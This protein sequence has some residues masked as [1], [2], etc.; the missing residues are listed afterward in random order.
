MASSRR[1]SITDLS[2]EAHQLLEVVRKGEP[3]LVESEGTDEAI[4][5][6][7]TDY[8]LLRAAMNAV[9]ERS[10]SGEDSLSEDALPSDADAQ[11]RYDQVVLH[12]LAGHISLSRAAE[13]LGCSPVELRTRFERLGL[14]QRI[15][16]ETPD[17]ARTDAK[18]ALAWMD[19]DD[20]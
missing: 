18:T 5:V 2:P 11:T 16:P 3:V 1:L 14:P 4:L 10:L 9:S 15:A 6:D 7:L 17:E 13:L 19:S 12:Y 20:A 8:R